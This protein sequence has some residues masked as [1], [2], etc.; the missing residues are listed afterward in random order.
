MRWANGR[1]TNHLNVVVHGGKAWYESLRFRDAQRSQ[2]ELAANN[3][4][5]KFQLAAMHCNDR[6][7]YTDAKAELLRSVLGDI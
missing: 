2:P 7:A 1:R 3:A 6:E 4:A 5:L